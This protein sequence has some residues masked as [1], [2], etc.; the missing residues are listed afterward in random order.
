MLPF[1]HFF[2]LLVVGGAVQTVAFKILQLTDFHLDVDYSQQGDTSNKCHKTDGS[3]GSLGEFGDYKCDAPSSLVENAVQS[4]AQMFPTPDLILWTGDNVPHIDGY[5]QDYVVKA[6]K[7][8]TDMIKNSF[9]GVPVLPTYGNHD[10][11]PSDQHAEND[12]LYGLIYD[13]WSEWLG[14][15][16]ETQRTFLLGGYYAT[17]FKGARFIVLNTNL[18]YRFDNATFRTPDDPA[19][20]F[21]FLEAE[22]KAAEQQKLPVHVV[23]HIAPG[24]YEKKANFSWFT[25]ETNKKF[26]D[27]IVPHVAN[28]RWMIFAHHHTDT[29]H[30]LRNEKGDAVQVLFCAPSVTPWYS[31]LGKGANNPAF[32]VYES[33]DNWAPL[34]FS[35][36]FVNLSSL[37][38][39]PLTNWQLEY[40]FKTAFGVADLSGASVDALIGRMEK[41]GELFK[42]YLDYNN[43]M[44]EKATDLS[45]GDRLGQ[46]CSL[47]HADYPRY[48]ACL[49]GVSGRSTAAVFFSALLAGFFLLFR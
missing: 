11:W 13:L 46:F 6:I 37:N 16:A 45:A 1:N 22:L 8:P 26:I 39:D 29:F 23:A 3:A 17:T 42:K 7:T 48:R 31:D 30:V 33:S 15:D 27:V 36:Y 25:E 2:L 43:V 4:A 28:I 19:G 47:R 44:Q 35:T 38:V 24:M 10:H 40:S 21:A 34:D 20:Q 41:D 32:R 14:D 5:N 12:P 18:Y 49:S 9:K